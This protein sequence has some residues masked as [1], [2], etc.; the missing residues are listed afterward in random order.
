MDPCGPPSLILFFPSDTHTHT[1]THAPVHPHAAPSLF[2]TLPLYPPSPPQALLS[3]HPDITRLDHISRRIHK[4]RTEALRN[5]SHMLHSSNINPLVFRHW[6][7]FVETVLEDPEAAN[8]IYTQ[9]TLL[10]DTDSRKRESA[11][12]QV[13]DGHGTEGGEGAE[14]HVMSHCRMVPVPCSL[15]H[16]G[17]Q[18]SGSFPLCLLGKTR[19]GEGRQPSEPLPLRLKRKTNYDFV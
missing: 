3:K 11:A 12:N 9:S 13:C 2:P 19:Q 16:V 15:A 17:H 8:R 1:H 6:G 18:T 4:H 10:R 7:L 14:E 5:F